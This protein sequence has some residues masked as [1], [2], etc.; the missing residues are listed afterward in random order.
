MSEK[1]ILAKLQH[2]FIVNMSGDPTLGDAHV[3]R[4]KHEKC[5]VYLPRQTDINRFIV[6]MMSVYSQIMSNLILTLLA[7]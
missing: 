5:L 2:P 3:A 7:Q 6:K 4:W 1:Q